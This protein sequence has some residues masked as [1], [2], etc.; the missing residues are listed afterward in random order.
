MCSVG[1]TLNIFFVHGMI[2]SVV[3]FLVFLNWEL[4]IKIVIV[5]KLSM[6]G[7]GTSLSSLQSLPVALIHIS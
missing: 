4:A 1:I 5:K 3:T 2:M 7:A 6:E